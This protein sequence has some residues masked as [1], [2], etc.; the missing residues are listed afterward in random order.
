MPSA[1]VLLTVHPN[2][3]EAELHLPLVELETAFGHPLADSPQTVVPRYGA[4]LRQYLTRHVRVQSPDGRTWAVRPGALRV[5]HQQTELNGPYE[6]LL[7]TLQ[8][9]PPPGADVRH[10]VLHDDAVIHQVVTHK[11]LVAVRQDWATGRV[12]DDAPPAQVGVIELN[13]VDNVIPPLVVNMAAGS[14]WTGFTAL[15]RLGT[16]HIADGTDHLLFLLALLLPAP[17]VV[18]GQR[19]GGFGGARYSVRRLLLLVTAFTAGHSLT[20]VLGTLGWVR[21]PSQPVETLIAASILVAAAHAVRPLFPG[22]EPWVA[23]GFGLVHGLAFAGTLAALQLEGGPLAWSLL[24]FNVGIE[25][26]QLLVVGLTVPW[27]LL[28]A[29]TPHYWWVRISGAA[30]AGLAAAAWLTERLSGHPNVLTRALVR[31]DPYAPWLLA[32]LAVVALLL[33]VRR[34]R[35]APKSS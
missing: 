28:L 14:S 26:M 22:R 11:I 12:H 35:P 27:L 6:E 16:R 29:R 23:A 5:Q 30:L 7:A 24:G 8:L 9:A 4:A 20:L 32:G 33:Y 13:V 17:L 3:L 21:L 34:T 25:L 10:F 15:V 1:L 31:A 2:R 18:A 19:W